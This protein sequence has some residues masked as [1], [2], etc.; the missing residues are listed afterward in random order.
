MPNGKLYGP[1]GIA[2]SGFADPKE[3]GIPADVGAKVKVVIATLPASEYPP[4]RTAVLRRVQDRVR[5]E[6]ARPVRD[7][8]LRG[9][10]PDAGRHPAGRGPGEVDR[11]SVVEQLF[12]TKDRQSVLGN[13]SINENGDTTLTDYGA[14]N[15]E[16]GAS[17]STRPSRRRPTDANPSAT[18]EQPLC[19]CGPG[20]L[21]RTS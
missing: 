5:R 8:R 2:E 17:S 12:A 11:A 21:S 20:S 14:Y 18:G 3:G 13:Y 15:I 19:P 6:P 9:D 4:E 7:L 16:N 1:D 10:E